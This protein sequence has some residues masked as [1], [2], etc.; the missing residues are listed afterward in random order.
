LVDEL[1]VAG[2]EGRAVGVFFWR[3]RRGGL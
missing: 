1:F 3:H 2:E